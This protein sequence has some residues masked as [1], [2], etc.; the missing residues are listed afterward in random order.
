MKIIAFGHRS[1]MG[2]DTAA[3]FLEESIISANKNA[4]VVR[5]GFADQVKK[6]AHDLYGWAGL[7]IGEYYEH[8]PEDR[9][10]VLPALGK[11]PVEMWIGF[12]NRV[13]DFDPDS[14]VNY[15]LKQNNCQFLIITDLRFPNELK[16]I[17]DRKGTVIKVV[18]SD[19]K[20][21]V[22]ES[23]DALENYQGWDYV[24]KDQDLPS[25]KQFT[26]N[27]AEELLYG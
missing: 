2:K 19:V 14:W 22:S 10:K 9:F 12:A 17:R 24:L 13:R 20:H 11:T 25:I 6:M 5:C 4:R 15:V 27:L 7:Q 26:R 16:L 21:I 1:R 18:R 23:D 3:V 8:N